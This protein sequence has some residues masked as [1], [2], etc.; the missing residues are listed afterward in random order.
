[1][2]LLPQLPLLNW[3]PLAGQLIHLIELLLLLQAH[4]HLFVVYE[5]QELP[6]FQQRRPLQF[7]QLYVNNLYD[8]LVHQHAQQVRH[9]QH[10]FP[11]L[12]RPLPL[13][14]LSHQT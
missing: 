8:F 4:A 3:H 14:R 10:E 2:V 6:Q 7:C 1:M 11:V 12:Q 9:H 5:L 13:T